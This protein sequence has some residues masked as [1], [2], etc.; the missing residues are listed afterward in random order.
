MRLQHFFVKDISSQPN[1]ISG[2]W[3]GQGSW[4]GWNI[5][6]P[7][8]TVAMITEIVSFSHFSSSHCYGEKFL[9]H[10]YAVCHSKLSLKNG[11]TQI[12]INQEKLSH[13]F[14]FYPIAKDPNPSNSVKKSAKTTFLDLYQHLS[15]NWVDLI[16]LGW[17]IFLKSPWRS[18][19]TVWAQDLL[20]G[21][22]LSSIV[23]LLLNAHV[24][25]RNNSRWLLLWAILWDQ[26]F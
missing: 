5:L 3:N 15:C 26:K 6:F 19:W 20:E 2:S 9:P 22:I 23:C 24:F 10:N 4:F 12:K 14:I 18:G 7:F 17:L 8:E 13:S 21:T 16:F 1:F 11:V 25:S